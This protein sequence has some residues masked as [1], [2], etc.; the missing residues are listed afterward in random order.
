MATIKKHIQKLAAI[1]TAIEIFK[2]SHRSWSNWQTTNV[3]MKASDFLAR[4][5][6]DISTQQLRCLVIYQQDEICL[7][8]DA[9][10]VIW[11]PSKYQPS[12]SGT[13]GRLN[14][15]RGFKYHSEIEFQYK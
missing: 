6:L 14:N 12:G 3:T 5:P 13:F 1:K 7:V 4:V 15:K 10:K 9:K 8:S 11:H 2:T